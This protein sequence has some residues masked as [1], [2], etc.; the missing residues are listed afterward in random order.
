MLLVVWTVSTVSTTVIEKNNIAIENST[1]YSSHIQSHS[2]IYY[3]TAYYHCPIK[4]NVNYY[5]SSFTNKRAIKPGSPK[6]P[7]KRAVNSFTPI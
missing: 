5:I 6:R 7:T 1:I 3:I 2:C 4:I